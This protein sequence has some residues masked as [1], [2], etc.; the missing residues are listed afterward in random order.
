MA[1]QIRLVPDG[2]WHRREQANGHDKTACGLPIFAFAFRDF[3]FD[4]NLCPKCFT[5]HEIETGKRQRI[6]RELD[7]EVKGLRRDDDDDATTTPDG[8]SQL[9]EKK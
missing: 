3:N 7:A 9:K 8:K 4:E 2:V 1:M 5:D 6:S